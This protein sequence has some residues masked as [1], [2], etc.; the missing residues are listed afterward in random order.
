MVNGVGLG[1][2]EARVSNLSSTS[3][4]Y[5]RAYATNNKGTSYGETVTLFDPSYINLPEL[6][7]AVQRE[8]LGRGNYSSMKSLCESSSVGGFADWRLPTLAELSAL[9]KLKDKIG[10]FSK[11]GKYWSSTPSSYDSSKHY[12]IDFNYGSQEI[13]HD[14]ELRSAR[15]VRTL[16]E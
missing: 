12:Y 6:G 15:A 16:T 9:Y 14:T 5:A 10:G 4:T 1:E 3:I 13:S 11:T 8:D 2:F 7:I